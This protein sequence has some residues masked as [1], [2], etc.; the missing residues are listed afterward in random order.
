MLHLLD[1]I[2]IHGVIYDKILS[3]SNELL[4]NLF[5][6][7]FIIQPFVITDSEF[8]IPVLGQGLMNDDITSMSG[9]EKAM[10]SMIISL[11][12]LKQSST[13]YNIVKLDEIDAP[14]DTTNRTQFILVL[15]MLMQNI[16]TD[17]V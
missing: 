4:A 7:T 13:K 9:G 11:A 17:N 15:D 8:R 3:L 6:G 10:I 1:T 12:L 5:G 14:L 2:S 16:T